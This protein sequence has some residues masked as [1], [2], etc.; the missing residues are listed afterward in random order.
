[1]H[2]PRPVPWRVSW[3]ILALAGSSAAQGD[4][5]EREAAGFASAP[6]GYLAGFVQEAETRWPQNR[7]LTVVCHGH[8]V[9]AAYFKTPEVRTFDAYPHLLHVALKRRF[10]FAVI[11]VI[12]TA[13]GGENS[14]SGAE[15]FERD[16]LRYRPDI[17]TI[18]YGLNDRRIGLESSREAWNS[19]IEAAQSGG[20]KVVLLTPT[21]DSGAKLADPNDPLNEQA[22]QIRRLAAEHGVAL[23]DSLAAFGRAVDAGTGLDALLSQPNHP[24]RAGH[25]LVAREIARLFPPGSE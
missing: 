22:V 15:R 16:V 12:V 3:L 4:R 10:P 1:M 6:R 2:Y 18:D 5:E 7:A 19:M 17:V 8:S 21:A 25:E 24:N 20:A 11:N 13:I 9:P 14:V 23:V